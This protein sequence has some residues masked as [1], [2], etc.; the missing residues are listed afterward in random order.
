MQKDELHKFIDDFS[1]NKLNHCVV[2]NNHD[3]FFVGDTDE[4]LKKNKAVTRLFSYG[5]MYGEEWDFTLHDYIDG[6]E[7]P[8]GKIQFFHSKDEALNFAQGVL[9]EICSTYAN[10][11]TDTMDKWLNFGLQIPD[12]LISNMNAQF[13]ENEERLEAELNAMRIEREKFFKRYCN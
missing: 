1:D 12:S 9:D 6:R 8:L 7:V 13:I 5:G 4:A 10:I 3:V 11:S 2:Y